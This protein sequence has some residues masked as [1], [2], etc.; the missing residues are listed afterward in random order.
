VLLVVLLPWVCA[1]LLEAWSKPEE[2]SP[3]QHLATTMA[4]AGRNAAQTLLTLAFL[5]Y[6]AIVYVDAIARTS[7]RM[8]VTHRH[9][10]EWNPSAMEDPERRTGTAHRRTGLFASVGSMW[11]GPA[12][13]AVV[14]V[15]LMAS[16]A[17][18]LGAA[19]PV[20][21]LWLVSPALAWWVS[22]P[23]ERREAN[24]DTADIAFLRK[25]ARRTWA[26]FETFVGPDDR[27]LPPDNEQEHPSP[28]VAHRTSPTNMGLSL[29]AG[30]TAY[31]FGFIPAGQLVE[32]TANA[33]ATMS[34]LERHEGHFYNWYD[35]QSGKPLPPLYISSVDS[36]NLA[37]HLMTLRT[38]LAAVADAPIV[39]VRWFEG[40]SD[41]AHVLAE[42]IGGSTPAPLSRLLRDLEAAYDSRPSTI[43]AV[44]QWL[45]RLAEDVSEIATKVGAQQRGAEAAA[46][47]GG[48]P[49]DDASFWSAALVGQCRAMQ[50]EVA[51]LAPWSA[52]PPVPDELGIFTM[53][54]GIP[55]LRELAALEEHVQAA[56]RLQPVTVSA[57]D[58]S[59]QDQWLDAAIEASR[60]A[61]ERVAEIERLSLLCDALA[62]MD[63][64]FLYD[65]PRHLLAIGYN[66]GERRRDASHYDLLASEARFASFVGIAQGQLPQENWF[67]LGRMLTSS[68]GE[69]VLLSWSGSMFEYLMP[70]LV[71]PSYDNTLLAETA[72]VCVDLQI[73]YGKLRGV[74]W[75]I[76]ESG[77]NAVDASLNYQYRAFGV[78]GLGLKRGLAEDLVIAPYASALALMVAPEAACANLRRLAA[79]GLA[80][81]FGLYE[82]IDYTPARLP[83]GQDSAVV[84]SF[85]A[86]HQGMVL[87][88][89]SYVLLGRPMQ[90]RFEAD[91]I[92]KATLLLLQ[93]RIPRAAVLYAQPAELSAARDVAAEAEPPVRVFDHPDTA[94][95]EVQLLSNG[96]YHVM[97]TNAGG[98]STRWKDLAVTRWR[99]D[100]TC[101]NWGTY[102]YIRDTAS[103]DF[104]SAAHQPTLQ[105]PVRYEAIFS[106]ARAEFRRRD[107]DF[108]SHIDIVV[109]PEDDIELRG[110]AS[111]TAR[112]HA[113]RSTSRAT[114]RWCSPHAAAD[115]LHPVFSNLFVQTEI[116]PQRH[117]ILC[118]RRPRRARSRRTGCST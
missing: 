105:R 8:L 39:D 80:G 114:P 112:G 9:L 32:R 20:L 118:T 13:A 75:G 76:S 1:V 66:V 44:R 17:P 69:R 83:R 85:M 2:A 73:A 7:W 78:P 19:A 54:R 55:T 15:L 36:G 93:E 37:G 108:E 99:E 71:M 72:R 101:D 98:G 88:S 113:A 33:L 49:G 70:Q 31:D 40:L 18:A 102:C 87:L 3:K 81:R 22:R 28:V 41:T 35:T 90:R 62:Q 46:Q 50:Q 89:L 48:E 67:A 84:R 16:D 34:A 21:L 25:L 56:R 61:R 42:A 24:L 107:R 97:V 82:A 4:A 27:W 30:L 57:G 6:E 94:S 68:G 51:F 45:D 109:S 103:G 77:Y 63:Y 86:H 43:A 52:L 64:E 29:L 14:G 116:V 115:A 110:C 5:P 100:S 117:A 11:M 95:P 26:F 10:L 60:R 74:P 96:R 38:G 47:S 91:P 59:A 92:F 104:W 23:L 111:R 65:R 58:R 106:E 12:I 53:L 79:E